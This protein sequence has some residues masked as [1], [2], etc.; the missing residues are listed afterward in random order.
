MWHPHNP[1]RRDNIIQ[2]ETWKQKLVKCGRSG[3]YWASY[4]PPNQG[5]DWKGG[6]IQH[7]QDQDVLRSGVSQIR[8][9]RTKST[10]VW[11]WQTRGV[12]YNY[13]IIQYR[14]WWNRNHFWSWKYLIPTYDVTRGTPE[15]IWRHRKLDWKYNQCTH[16]IDQGGFNKLPPPPSTRSTSISVPWGVQWGNL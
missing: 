16:K 13:E 12:P 7:H 8:D 6:G 2:H 10:N 5:N 15:I 9:L 1:L 4:N 14:H 3:T 11:K